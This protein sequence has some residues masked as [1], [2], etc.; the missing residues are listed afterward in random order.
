V[1]AFTERMSNFASEVA[2]RM[3]RRTAERGREV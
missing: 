3:S 2:V 1:T